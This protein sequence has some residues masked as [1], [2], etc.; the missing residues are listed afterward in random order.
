MSIRKLVRSVFVPR[1]L[2]RTLT[3]ILFKS[4]LIIN[5]TSFHDRIIKKFI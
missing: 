1:L 3:R 4:Q 2:R 5:F